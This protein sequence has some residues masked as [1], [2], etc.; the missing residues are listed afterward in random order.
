MSSTPRSERVHIALFGNRNSG[1]SSLI[2]ALTNQPL[3]IVSPSKGTTTDPV[4]KSIEI[5][6]LGPCVLIDTAGLDDEG[7]LG[8]LRI[9][10]S[11]DVLDKCDIAL[12]VI[13]GETGVTGHDIE[14]A[15]NIRGRKRPLAVLLNKI[16]K[17]ADADSAVKAATDRL[18]LPVI[19]VSAASGRG[20]A[21]VKNALPALLPDT[22]DDAQILDGIVNAG[23][24]AVLVCPIDSA[25]PKGRLILPQ[26]Q[27][28]RE[29][30]DA[31]CGALV[32]QT[33][34]LAAM[35][36]KLSAPPRIVITDSQAFKEVSAIVP[37]SI[38]LTSFSILFARYKGNLEQLTAGAAALKTLRDGDR[39]L[40]S[41]GCTHH[42][43]CDDIGTVKIPRW[44]KQLT[45]KELVLEYSSGAGFPE[46]LS[47]Y[48]LIIHCGG[49][50]LTRR[51]MLAR[52][53]KAAKSGVPIVNY[54]IMIACVHGILERAAAPLKK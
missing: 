43:Q 50:M 17:I 51:A 20:L 27:V 39:V 29:L 23:D 40:I 12:M 31:Q 24:V 19:P 8:K 30:C 32:C 34:E 9:A 6:P 42:R 45:G 52:L 13:D 14:L 16:D 41:E 46:D 53:E 18:G 15:A 22:G 5:L 48:R 26:Q 44:L 33:G 1:K 54:G 25:A 7:E 11:L 49:C 37:A 3:A 38:P 28:I 21:E 2:N 47:H 36:G 35:L 4:Y 10:K